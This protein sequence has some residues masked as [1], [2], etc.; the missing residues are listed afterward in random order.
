M[1]NTIATTASVDLPESDKNNSEESSGDRNNQDIYTYVLSTILF[2]IIVLLLLNY[3]LAL[4]K[5]KTKFDNFSKWLRLVHTL[6][7]Y[8]N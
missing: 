3:S 4:T 8:W 7:R 6:R 5:S 2:I 1:A